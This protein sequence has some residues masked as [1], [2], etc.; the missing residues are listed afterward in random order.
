MRHFDNLT[1]SVSHTTRPPRAGETDGKDYF[2]VSEEAF[3]RHIEADD[4][5]EWAR[6]HGHYYGTRAS[7]LE[8]RLSEGQHILLD[9]DVQGA[10]Q[11][12]RKYPESITIF[13]MPPS[14]DA[15]RR[16][17]ESRGEDSAGVIDRRLEN[18]KQEMEQKDLYQH[19]IVNDDLEQAISE[20]IA[21]ID[22]KTT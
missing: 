17:L 2:F 6:V 18:A 11:I 13:V 9:I 7:F 19:V 5:A 4:W 12:I 16:R 10:A 1:Y 15:L 8:S 14:P 20:L 21:I 3:K 22:E